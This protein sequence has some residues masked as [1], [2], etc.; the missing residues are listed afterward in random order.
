MIIGNGLAGDNLPRFNYKK[1][2]KKKRE[3]EYFKQ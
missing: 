2:K 3:V 1:E